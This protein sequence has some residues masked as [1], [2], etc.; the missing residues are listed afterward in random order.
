MHSGM[1]SFNLN[2]EL[3]PNPVIKNEEIAMCKSRLDL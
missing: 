3:N 2:L 1:N